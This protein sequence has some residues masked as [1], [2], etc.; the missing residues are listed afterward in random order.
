MPTHSTGY[1]MC[2]KHALQGHLESSH[3]WEK[4]VV[5][6]LQKLGFLPTKHE[7]CLYHAIIDGCHILLLLQVDD[8]QL[9]QKAHNLLCTL[10]RKLIQR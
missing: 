5:A 9:Q 3:L 10:L 6:V 7:P 4:H 1:A 2:I 8:F